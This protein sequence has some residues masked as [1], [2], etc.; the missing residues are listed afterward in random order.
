MYKGTYRIALRLEVV[1]DHLLG[2]QQHHGAVAAEH[3]LGE[4]DEEFGSDHFYVLCVRACCG[5]ADVSGTIAK[6]TKDITLCA[7]FL[8]WFSQASRKS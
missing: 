3:A 1:G 4:V 5:C 7:I 6:K 8:D 2:H